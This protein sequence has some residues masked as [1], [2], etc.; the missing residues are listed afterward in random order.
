[1][2][3]VLTVLSQLPLAEAWWDFDWQYRKQITIYSEEI[4]TDLTNFPVMISFESDADLANHAQIDGNDI[5]FTNGAGTKLSHEIEFYD[6]NAGRLLAWVNVPFVSSS[7]DTILYMYYGNPAAGSQQ[8]VE[9]VW[10]SNFV[11]VHHLEENSVQDSGPWQKYAGN[12]ILDDYRNG[13][14]SVIYDS[15]TGIYHFFC[16][17]GSVLHFTS[18]DGLSWTEDPGNPILSDAGL[19]ITWKEWGNWYMLYRYGSPTVIGLATSPDGINWTKDDANNP[20]VS[21]DLDQWDDRDIES[22]G[23]IKV[24]STYYL[25]YSTVGSVPGLGR[26]TGLVTSTNLT[27]WTKNSNNPIL[28][29]GRYC[30]DVFSYGGYYYLLVPHYTSIPFGE[31]E[32]YR[33]VNPTFYEDEREFLGIIIEP[34]TNYEWD[35]HRFDAPY[36]LTDDIYRN[37]FGASNNELYVYYSGTGT[38]SGNGL[39]WWTGL[40]VEP[41]ISEA[42]DRNV[43]ADVV[44]A[45]S[46]SNHIDGQGT[47]YLNT[48][49]NGKIDGAAVF[50]GFDDYIDFLDNERLRGMSSLTVEAWVLAEAGNNGFISKWESWT[51]GTGGSFILWQQNTGKSAWGVITETGWARQFEDTPILH[52]GQWHD[53]VGVYDGSEIKLFV[54]GSETGSPV[55]VTGRI[56]ST[57]QPLNIGKY[58]ETQMNGLID[59]VR[60]SNTSRSE[61]W[62]KAS[63]KNQLLPGKFYRV[64]REERYETNTLKLDTVN[65]S[66]YIKPGENVI[67][68]MEVLNLQQKVNACQAMLGYSSSYFEEPNSGTGCVAPGGGVWDLVIWDSWKDATGE[69]GEIDTAIG[70]DAQGAVGT[71]EDGTAAFITLISRSDVEGTTRVVFRPDAYPDPGLL[72]STFL[73]DMNGQPIWPYKVDGQTIV[74][75]G[76]PPVLTDLEIEKKIYEFGEIV[77]TIRITAD[78]ALSGLA[79]PPDIDVNGPSEL[80]PV[81]IDTQGPVYSWEIGLDSD[82]FDDIYTL[83]VTAADMAGNEITQMG[84]INIVYLG[85]LEEFCDQWLSSGLDLSGDLDDNGLVDFADYAI[86][87]GYWLDIA[88]QGWQL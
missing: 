69:P 70:L 17:W 3:F 23:V 30:V 11:M 83:T 74:I 39:D 27:E 24:G 37:T 43:I 14:G 13:Y 42:L 57:D 22:W 16:S 20:V 61:A 33:D 58:P 73:G 63:Y 85:D 86:L 50:D 9:A 10:D 80:T 8:N 81:F 2:L 12:P 71:D 1:M 28:T 18:S 40:C 47:G 5:L 60:I 79:G 52:L 65:T 78:D 36:V 7:A 88:P 32:L 48:T 49:A 53:L 45:D 6:S 44:I 59:E 56:A 15:D 29:G 76:T 31:V 66:I 25:W 21:G 26:C 46:T 87:A 77:V 35:N 55:P 54:D 72:K 75:D 62:I 82:H 34:G 68:K 67:T 84:T 51:A 38:P 4:D 41:N 64:A 19:P